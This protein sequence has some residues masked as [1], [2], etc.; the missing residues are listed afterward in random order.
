M[1]AITDRQK[2]LL[3]KRSI[4][5]KLRWNDMI[6]KFSVG[7]KIKIVDV[8]NINVSSTKSPYWD[9]EWEDSI[10]V[11]SYLDKIRLD[12]VKQIGIIEDVEVLKIHTRPRQVS[13]FSYRIRFKDKLLITFSEENLV[14]E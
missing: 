10:G 14:K 2:V 5:R 11:W 6:P 7:N 9:S 13:P 12:K 8:G 4:N 3:Y 1:K